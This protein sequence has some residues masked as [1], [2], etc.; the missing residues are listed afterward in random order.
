LF[1]A[2][3]GMQNTRKY[4]SFAEHPK[5]QFLV[6]KDIDVSKIKCGSCMKYLFQ[7]DKCNHQFESA[8]SNVV[9]LGR[10]CPY[11]CV[12][13]RKLCHNDECND[14]F[15]RSFASHP[16]SKC[17]IDKTLDPRRLIGGSNKSY[18]FLC[19]ICDH[20]FQIQLVSVK[21]GCWCPY[22]CSPPKM[23]CNDDECQRCFDRSFAA[24]PKSACLADKLINPRMISIQNDK[25][26]LFDCDKCSHQF[27]KPIYSITSK[28]SPSWCPYCVNQ[29]L[30]DCL[31]CF[32]KSFALHPKSAF[33]VDKTIDLGKITLGA[34]KKL[35]F[36]CDVCLSKFES[37]VYHVTSKNNPRWCPFCT[38]KSEKILHEYLLT[39]YPDIIYQYRVEWCKNKNHLP[40]DICIPSLNIII[41]LDGIQH[42]KKISNW[43]EPEKRRQIDIYKM[44]CAIANGFSIIRLF[45]ED[46]FYN[47]I[48]WKNE[49]HKYIK[50]YDSPVIVFIDKK[51]L[52]KDHIDDMQEVL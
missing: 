44:T 22:C 39:L 8:I 49:L 35:M 12:P 36:E 52:Y 17:L 29:K 48:D 6:D 20:V 40:F 23:L 41:E 19:D 11:C 32:H 34:N 31:D 16:K 24:H 9:A 28:T 14:C 1:L 4:T 47:R 51:G 7:C 37:A 10:W 2:Y 50:K 38:N 43:G 5:S 3:V 26:Y 21:A 30:C 33:V 42:F 46:L 25:S 13:S 15:Q 45:Q 27:T 18:E